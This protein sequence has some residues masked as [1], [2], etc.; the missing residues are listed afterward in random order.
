MAW[1]TPGVTRRGKDAK[2]LIGVVGLGKIPGQKWILLELKAGAVDQCGANY[3]QQLK[4]NSGRQSEQSL[5]NVTPEASIYRKEYA[6][7]AFCP[8][9]IFGRRGR[10]GTDLAVPGAKMVS[11]HTITTKARPPDENRTRVMPGPGSACIMT[12]SGRNLFLQPGR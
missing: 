3:D 2:H 12:H 4:G 5:L 11:H 8:F 10:R 6:T 9:L 1:P 7:V